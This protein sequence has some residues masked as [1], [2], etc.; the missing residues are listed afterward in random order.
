M[1]QPSRALALS[2]HMHIAMRSS[3]RCWVPFTRA[4]FVHTTLL[5][6]CCIVVS[7]VAK[8]ASRT[9]LQDDAMQ[10]A[11]AEVRQRRGA[12]W[13]RLHRSLLHTWPL[14]QSM[15]GDIAKDMSFDGGLFGKVRSPELLHHLVNIGS[16]A[17][18]PCTA[19]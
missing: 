6:G 10:M 8:Q 2:F 5:L 3:G 18:H 9:L 14:A 19:P 13:M 16:T 12:D 7:T 15:E 11:A 1:Q 4:D 17:V